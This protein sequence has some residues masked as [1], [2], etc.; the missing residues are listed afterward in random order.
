MVKANRE[1]YKLFIIGEKGLSA[2]VRPFPDLIVRTVSE[3]NTPINF[4]MAA[5]IA[6]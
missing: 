3:V 6:H 4:P 2:L 5:S 1:G